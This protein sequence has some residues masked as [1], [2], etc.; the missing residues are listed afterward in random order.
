[1]SEDSD[2]KIG[3]T[4]TESN[5]QV[6]V[7]STWGNM[8]E[9][10]KI[11]MQ[12]TIRQLSTVVS[13]GKTAYKQRCFVLNKQKQCWYGPLPKKQWAGSNIVYKISFIAWKLFI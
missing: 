13:Y 12:S 5:I 10:N 6:K 4:M 7:S 9:N 3:S 1:M 2:G 11:R 8:F